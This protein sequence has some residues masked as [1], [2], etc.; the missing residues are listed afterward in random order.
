MTVAVSRLICRRAAD[1]AA[2]Q[3]TS[4]CSS[5]SANVR[6]RGSHSGHSHP[7]NTEMLSSRCANSLDSS[8]PTPTDV[9]SGRTTAIPNRARPKLQPMIAGSTD[10]VGHGQQDALARTKTHIHHHVLRSGTADQTSR[11]R[12]HHSNTGQH[13]DSECCCANMPGRQVIRRCFFNYRCGLGLFD[14]HRHLATWSS[15]EIRYL[16]SSGTIVTRKR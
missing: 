2:G 15:L 13:V 4:V 1:L 12:R 8:R 10:P 5:K 11:H 16:P 7:T 9:P 6:R 3:R 14:Q